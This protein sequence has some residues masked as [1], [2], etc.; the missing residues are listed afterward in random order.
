[1]ADNQDRRDPFVQTLNDKVVAL[2]TTVSYLERDIKEHKV[3]TEKQFEALTTTINTRFTTIDGK[4]DK[5]AD[6]VTNNKVSIAKILGVGAVVA[7]VAGG[8]I[9]AIARAA[10]GA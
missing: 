6:A 9:A 10:V 5:I 4:I 8:I 1:M 3:Q 2:G 7:L